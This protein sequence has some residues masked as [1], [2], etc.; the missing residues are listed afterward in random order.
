ME[1]NC[2]LFLSSKASKVSIDLSKKSPYDIMHLMSVLGKLK[3]EGKIK[4]KVVN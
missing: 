1:K 2:N 3:K 4:I